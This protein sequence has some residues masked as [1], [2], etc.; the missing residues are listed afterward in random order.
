MDCY[1]ERL[2]I[3]NRIEEII[4][5]KYPGD[6]FNA[7]YLTLIEDKD[8][9]YVKAL[10]IFKYLFQLGG[11]A[12]VF[13]WNEMWTYFSDDPKL[14]E[15]DYSK[16]ELEFIR[17]INKFY[18]Q[19]CKKHGEGYSDIRNINKPIESSRL[20]IK[21]YDADL[22]SKYVVFLINNPK[23][24]ETFY[25]K[26]FNKEDIP[27]YCGQK[28]RKLSFAITTKEGYFIGSV[29]LELMRCDCLYN[30]E[31]FIMPEYRHKGYAFEAVS[32][33]IDAAQNKSLYILDETIRYGVYEV[34]DANIRCIEART[35]IDNYPSKALLKKCGFEL[36]GKIPYF[37]KFKDT[38]IEAEQYDLLI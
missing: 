11:E 31:Y 26:E 28:T 15:K 20:I 36:Y 5:Q 32:R 6:I 24:F 13:L 16:E 25:G 8:A 23:E 38:Y 27:H 10:E 21:P 34:K 3:N 17:S 22:N 33:I 12:H 4:E 19:E 1:D 2:K 35:S 37:D 18:I 9:D 30:L 29:A 14:D 7:Y